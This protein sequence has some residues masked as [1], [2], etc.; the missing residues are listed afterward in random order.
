[1]LDS[2]KNVLDLAMFSWGLIIIYNNQIVYVWLQWCIN[3]QC[4]GNVSLLNQETYKIKY[5]S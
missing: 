4:F 5:I 2:K 3:L 1:M